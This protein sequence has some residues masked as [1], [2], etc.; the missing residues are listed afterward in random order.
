MIPLRGPVMSCH[1][2]S[3]VGYISP[4]GTLRLNIP[5]SIPIEAVRTSVMCAFH[6]HD[7]FTIRNTVQFLTRNQASHIRPGH[8]SQTAHKVNDLCAFDR[9]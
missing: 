1:A 6:D 2:A 3:L 5:S 4:C 8:L 9:C 7:L